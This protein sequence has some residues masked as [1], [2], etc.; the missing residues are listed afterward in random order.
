[1]ATFDLTLTRG[2]ITYP[3][4]AE[5]RAMLQ[6]TSVAITL[7]VS[8]ALVTLS[9]ITGVVILAVSAHETSAAITSLIG[10][11]IVGMLAYAVSQLRQ[12][13][14]AVTQQATPPPPE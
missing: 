9:A 5:I 2:K 8:V 3:S 1:M 6:K 13:R 7:I 4:R 14:A 11:P 12:V 10:G